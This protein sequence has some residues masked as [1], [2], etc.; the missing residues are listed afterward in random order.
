M[1]IPKDSAYV[2]NEYVQVLSK[3]DT[4]VL[5]VENISKKAR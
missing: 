3:A 5:K 4:S 1:I 2:Y